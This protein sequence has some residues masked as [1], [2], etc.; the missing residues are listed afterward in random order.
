LK[1]GLKVP[2]NIIDTD[3]SRVRGARRVARDDPSR[4]AAAVS[5]WDL[6]QTGPV[7]MENLKDLVLARMFG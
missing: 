5:S 7:P 3:E 6:G 4:G 2:F 1:L